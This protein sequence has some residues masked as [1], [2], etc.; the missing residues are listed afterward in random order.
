MERIINDGIEMNFTTSELPPLC[1]ANNYYYYLFIKLR[2]IQRFLGKLV[3]FEIIEFLK[4]FDH[5]SLFSSLQDLEYSHHLLKFGLTDLRIRR[6]RGDLIQMF[7]IVNNMERICFHS[8][9]LKRPTSTFGGLVAAT[10]GIQHYLLR[11]KNRYIGG[12]EDSKNSQFQ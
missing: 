10:Y 11:N 5:L 12:T 3:L 9:P 4:F 1:Q 2:R 7:K 8:R 6:L